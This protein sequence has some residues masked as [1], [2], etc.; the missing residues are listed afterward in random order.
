MGEE[1][2]WKVTIIEI[3]YYIF[4]SLLVELMCE[5]ILLF[6]L[7]CVQNLQTLCS[8]ITFSAFKGR[9]L[10]NSLNIVG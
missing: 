6:L 4:G 7:H 1:E 3:C 9:N 2:F 10:S 5:K 8:E